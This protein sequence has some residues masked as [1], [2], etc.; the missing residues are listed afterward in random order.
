ML[1]EIGSEFWEVSPVKSDKRYFLSGRTALE[2]IIRDIKKNSN[3]DSV[4]LPSYCCHTMIEPFCRHKIAV[5][6]YSVYFDDIT[7][8][9]LKIPDRKEN[10]IFYYMTYFGYQRISGLDMKK[11]RKNHNIVI[12]DKTHSWLSGLNRQN[13]DYSFASFRKWS[14]FD[15]IAEAEKLVGVFTNFPC[16]THKKYCKLRK[17]AFLL[18]NQFIS[19]GY[20]QKEE[21]LSLYN[22]AEKLLETDYMGYQPLHDTMEAFL[23][24]DLGFLAEKRKQNARI[25]IQGLKEIPEIKLLFDKVED[26]DVPLF[27]PIMI[28]DKRDDLRKYL[29]D[30]KVYCPVHWPLSDFHGKL[31]EPEKILYEQELS[32]ICD[33]RYSKEEMERVVDLIYQYFK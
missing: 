3:I 31:N 1:N 15:G 13:Y 20:G 30:R 22:E 2:Y 28:K 19:R 11:I 6:F 7:G 32:L 23:N 4:L 24:L 9:C 21:F 33:Q 27:V 12:E 29:I 25:L 26:Q 5:R 14:G 10:E 8:I 17:K 16:K 18:K